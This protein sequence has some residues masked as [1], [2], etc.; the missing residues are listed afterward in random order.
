MT[1]DGQTGVNCDANLQRFL[2]PRAQPRDGCNNFK[3]GAH[4]APRIIFV[5]YRIAEIYEKAVAKKLGY[6]TAV[7]ANQVG[8]DPLVLARQIVQLFRIELSGKRS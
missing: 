1:H 3:A 4:R 6:V 7:T 5:R 2:Q 8:A